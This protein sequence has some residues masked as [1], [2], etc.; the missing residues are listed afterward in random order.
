LCILGVVALLVAAAQAEPYWIAYEGDDYPENCGW[1]RAYGDGVH[2]PP[3]DE[4]DRWLDDGVL[5]VDTSRNPLLWEYYEID[6]QINPGSGELFVAEWRVMLD[7]HSGL[8]DGTVVIARDGVPG[9]VA[10]TLLNGYLLLKNEDVLIP[11]T[12][13]QFHEY[14]FQSWD[15]EGYE[16]YIDGQLSYVGQFWTVTPLDSFVAWGAGVQGASSTSGWDYFRFGVI[17]E[18]SSFVLVL[19]ALVCHGGRQ[20]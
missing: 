12:P 10:M 1:N 7:L 11:I 15:M 5:W 16:L 18:P 17:P 19:G 14:R 9:D 4:P 20:R 3:Q 6:R 13:G 8:F 2:V